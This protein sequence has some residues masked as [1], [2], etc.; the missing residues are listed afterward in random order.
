MSTS[1]NTVLVTGATGLLGRQVVAAFEEKKWKV[2]GTGFS[3]A[4]PPVHKVNLT[5]SGAVAQ[6]LEQESYAASLATESPDE[7]LS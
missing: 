2:V 7:Q 5:D 3:R 4:Q 6:L 1:T